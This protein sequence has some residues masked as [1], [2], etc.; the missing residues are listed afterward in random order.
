MLK[1]YRSLWVHLGV[2]IGL[3]GFIAPSVSALSEP[4]SR[5]TAFSSGAGTV[6]DPFVISTCAQLQEIDDVAGNLNKHYSLGNNIDCSTTSMTPMVNGST[7]FRGTLAGNNRSISGVS[8]NCSTDNCGLFTRVYDAVIKDITF[9]APLVTSSAKYVGLIAG[10][11]F[12]SIVFDN[13]TITG[14]SVSNTYAASANNHDDYSYT[15]GLIGTYG[16]TLSSGAPNGTISDI[17]SSMVVNGKSQTG[18][19]VGEARSG[20]TLIISDTAISGNVSGLSWVGGIAGTGMD[21]ASGTNTGL[22]VRRAQVTASAVTGAGQSI[23]GVLGFGW[24]VNIEN[25]TSTADVSG[26]ATGLGLGISVGTGQGAYVGGIAGQISGWNST[27]Q[28]SG[29][30]GDVEASGTDGQNSVSDGLI[31]ATS[32]GGIIG[33]ARLTNLYLTRVYHVGEVSGFQQVGGLVGHLSST[34]A[35]VDSYSRSDLVGIDATKHYGG[36]IGSVGNT[37]QISRSYFAG[38]QTEITATARY[39]VAKLDSSSRVTCNGFFFD[40]TLL[41]SGRT[42]S[43]ANRCGGTD[44]PAS[45]STASMKTAST[46]TTASWNFTSGSAVWTI[47]PAV[48][49]GYPFHSSAGVDLSEP[50]LTSGA[51]DSNGTSLVLTF[52]E[53]LHVT[54]AAASAFTVTASAVIITPTAAVVSGSTVTLTLPSVIRPSANVTIA[55]VAPASNAAT[56]NTAVQDL[57][58]ND[59]LSFAGR[60]VTNNS[61]ADLIAPTASWTEPATPSSSRTLIYTLTFSEVVSSIA[62]GDFSLTGTA[63]GCAATP[64]ASTANVTV[65]VSVTCTG[66]GTVIVRLGANSVADAASN[67]GPTSAVTA[68][69]ITINTSV[70]TTSTSPSTTVAPAGVSLT[71]TPVVS[72]TTVAIGQGQISVVSSTTSTST[73]RTGAASAATSSTSSTSP[74]SSTSSTTSSTVPQLSSIDLPPTEVGGSSFLINGKVMEAVIVRENNRLVITAGPLVVRIWAVAADGSRLSLD[75]DGRLR[76]NEGDSVTVNASG[77]TSNSKAEVRLY[78]TPILLGRTNID[79]EGELVGSYEIP[80]GVESGNHNVVLVGERNGEDVVMSLS[81]VLGNESSSRV[82]TTALVSV[83]LLAVI[84]ALL[85][86]AIVRRRRADDEV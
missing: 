6:A 20:G 60:S 8:L 79:G 3:V 26:R 63:T 39:S 28:D 27:I 70:N 31:T 43:T 24:N 25:S 45:K 54:T 1:K 46:F 44:G 56:S 76:V 13:I 4:I 37:A 19:I 2:V 62:A 65:S 53:S 50:T 21:Q 22:I 5:G 86:P 36:V 64:A 29:S 83:L 49:D 32:V 75:T 35:I 69:T 23:G 51:L 82:L 40:S 59:A 71:T 41:G 34:V 38:T 81:V 17:V 78:S 11:A 52:S 55:Y 61:T 9:V 57:S 72:P 77:F 58:G 7:F 18:G 67:T 84:G 12:D 66:D 42:S 33:W 80:K 14:G 68:S 16:T 48:N 73:P 74:T 15:G 47:D 10:R 30:T 85:I